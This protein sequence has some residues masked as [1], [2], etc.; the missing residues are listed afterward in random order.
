MRSTYVKR[1]ARQIMA[2]YGNMVTDNFEENKKLLNEMFEIKS[3]R[4][5]NKVAGYLVRLV[6][7][8]REEYVIPTA[9]E[10]RSEEE[11]EREIQKYEEEAEKAGITE[12]AAEE[13]A[14]EEAEESVEEAA[15]EEEGEEQEV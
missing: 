5:R 12:E 3:K 9:E 15:E 14:E 10:R 8:G 7:L 2:N 4:L 1:I 13:E 6:K 11:Y